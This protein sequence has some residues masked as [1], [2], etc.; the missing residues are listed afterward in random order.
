MPSDR[1]AL[2]RRLLLEGLVIVASI[3]LAFAVDASWD[4]FR[5]GQRTAAYLAALEGE[6]HEARAE[7]V[8]Q[9]EEHSTQLAA[10]HELLDV[11]ATGEEDERLWDGLRQLRAVYVYG[12]SHPVFE[13]LASSGGVDGSASPDLR[14]A[15]LRYGQR[16]DFLAELAA[17]ERQLWQDH[18]VPFLSERVDG[19]RYSDPD[20]ARD[21]APRFPPGAATLYEDRT[22]QN[23]LLLRAAHVSSQLGLDSLVLQAT[24]EVLA[25]IAQL[26]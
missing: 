13:D 2:A 18:M 20:E 24:D 11:L 19:L 1:R 25:E 9:I 6:F 5:D 26:R 16:K 12:P 15:L 4:R 21:R 23:L 7:M 10:I 22:F 14:F 8:E 17:R 3:L